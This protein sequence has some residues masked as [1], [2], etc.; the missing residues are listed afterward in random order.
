MSGT[1]YYYKLIVVGYKL[2]LLPLL[3]HIRENSTHIQELLSLKLHL[4]V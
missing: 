2:V 3:H 4:V 1:I